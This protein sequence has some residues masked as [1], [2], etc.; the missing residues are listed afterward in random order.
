MAIFA[1][2]NCWVEQACS[3][4]KPSAEAKKVHPAGIGHAGLYLILTKARTR[5]AS[6]PERQVT[7]P[8]IVQVASSGTSTHILL[9]CSIACS[10]RAP[11]S[12]PFE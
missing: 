12:E 9:G 2:D 11:K 6:R 3:Y 5:V 7:Y 1:H 4:V 8:D 10:A